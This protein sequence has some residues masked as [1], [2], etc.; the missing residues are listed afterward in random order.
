MVDLIT[1]ERFKLHEFP[2]NFIEFVN[3]F[4]KCSMIFEIFSHAIKMNAMMARGG[5]FHR[6]TKIPAGDF[7]N[8]S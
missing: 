8:S 7:R 4:R 5:I 1:I 3:F 6:D 2:K